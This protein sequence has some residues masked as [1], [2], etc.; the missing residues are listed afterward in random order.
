MLGLTAFVDV[1]AT[2]EHVAV[3]GGA[4]AF[5]TARTTTRLMAGAAVPLAVFITFLASFHFSVV[6]YFLVTARII[7]QD[8]VKVI[9]LQKHLA[10][11]IAPTAGAERVPIAKKGM[12]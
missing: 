6:A 3:V 10:V 2:V 7:V 8:F 4:H 5:C 9:I 12:S 1:L 11:I